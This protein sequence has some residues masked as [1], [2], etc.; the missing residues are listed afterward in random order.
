MSLDY[1]V[2]A[3]KTNKPG[4]AAP[5]DWDYIYVDP[6]HYEAN[7][8]NDGRSYNYPLATIAKAQEIAGNSRNALILVKTKPLNLERPRFPTRRGEFIR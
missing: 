2:A 7:D 1:R 6:D 8:C 4:I 3:S 5:R